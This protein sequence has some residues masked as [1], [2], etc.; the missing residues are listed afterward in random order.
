M[1]RKVRNLDAAPEPG[2][3]YASER[4]LQDGEAK[5]PKARKPL[6]NKVRYTPTNR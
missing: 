2:A 1:A 3:R 6:T 4:T 5:P